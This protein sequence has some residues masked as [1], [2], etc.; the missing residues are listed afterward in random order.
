MKRLILVL[1]LCLCAGSA[2]AQTT[3]DTVDRPD[4]ISRKMHPAD[5]T[6][7]TSMVPLWRK[8]QT[9]RSSTTYS[10]PTN[11]TITIT[12]SNRY[13]PVSGYPGY[14]WYSGGF[15]LSQ[16]LATQ[17]GCDIHHTDTYK[18]DIYAVD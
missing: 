6:E 16:W 14:Q 4:A 1:L 17:G 15:S 7:V 10:W 9:H 18:N 2:M 13:T 11:A 3:L 12:Q 8:F 5:G